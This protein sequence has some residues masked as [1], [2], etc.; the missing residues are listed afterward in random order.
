M[1]N[2]VYKSRTFYAQFIGCQVS[3]WTISANYY[4]DWYSNLLK[5]VIYIAIAKHETFS[6]D[7]IHR[8]NHVQNKVLCL[9]LYYMFTTPWALMYAMDKINLIYQTLLHRYHFKLSINKNNTTISENIRITF[10][11][12][13]RL[14]TQKKIFMN[15]RLRCYLMLFLSMGWSCTHI[16]WNTQSIHE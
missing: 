2:N 5:N 3:R 15:I 9:Y 14:T 10:L 11:Y 1:R 12:V 4:V 8:D 6:V 16:Q 13:K 7:Y